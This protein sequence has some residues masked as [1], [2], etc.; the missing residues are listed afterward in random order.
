VKSFVEA[1]AAEGAEVRELRA[2]QGDRLAAWL[3][4]QARERG[5]RFGPGAAATL[6]ER[7]GGFV[8]SGDVDRRL[9][10]QLAVSELEKLG[11]YRLDAEIRS[12][13]VRALVPEAIPASLWSLVDAVG[14]RRG[15]EALEL[16]DRALAATPEPVLVSLFHRRIRELIEVLDLLSGGSSPPEIG[17]A[18]KIGHEFR[19][20]MLVEQARAWDAGELDAA[21]AG[22]LDVDSLIKAGSSRRRV[23]LAFLLWISDRT[24]AGGRRAFGGRPA[25]GS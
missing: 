24:S 4:A 15:R 8:R 6:A 19:V 25:G 12:E 11:L 13:D 17:R 23:Q 5:L 20:R 7:V 22:L 1:L 9:Q 16:L 3:D 2:L 21:L 10:S 14:R 18:L